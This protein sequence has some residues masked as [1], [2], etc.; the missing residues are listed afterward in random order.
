MPKVSIILP[1]YNGQAYI[2]EAI[3]SMK[4]LAIKIAQELDLLPTNVE[5]ALKLLHLAARSI[6]AD[7]LLRL[8]AQLEQ[9][10]PWA[11]RRPPTCVS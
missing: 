1:T 5:Q 11:D 3:K 6:S 7:L 8:A 2:K 10:R 4:D 9:A